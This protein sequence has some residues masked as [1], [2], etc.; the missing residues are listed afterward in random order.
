MTRYLSGRILAIVPILL[1]ISLLTFGMIHLIPGDPVTV[2]LGESGGSP[3]AAAQ[4]RHEL[5]LDKPLVDQ[6]GAFLAHAVTGNLGVSVRSGRPVKNV[7]AEQLPSTLELAA[8]SL[9][10]AVVVGIGLGMLAAY[11]HGTWIDNVATVTATLGVSVP[12]FWLGLLVVL[13]FSVVLGWVPVVGTGPTQLILPT[14]TLG[15][16]LSAVIARLT[17]STLLDVLGQDYIRTARAKGL[18]EGLVVMK[19]ALRNALLPVLNIVGIQFGTL[20]TGAVV[21]EA[22]FARQGIGEIL[23]TAVKGRDLPLVQGIVLLVAVTFVVVNLCVDILS[24]LIDPR[25]QN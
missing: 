19:H 8:T 25:V 12:I 24:M 15:F 11:F 18:S 5:G 1:G 23:V 21:V 6:Y 4:L 3:E 20:I 13:L 17:R 7:I 14:V 16:A 10:F 22:V 9:A 2:M